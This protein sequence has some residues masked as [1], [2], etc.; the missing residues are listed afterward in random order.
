MDRSLSSGSVAAWYCDFVQYVVVLGVRPA[1]P[2]HRQHRM[3]ECNRGRCHTSVVSTR[4][5]C[6]ESPELLVACLCAAWCRTCDDYRT[7]FDRLRNE[8]A[9]GYRFLWVDIEDDEA[10][11]GD[12]DIDDFPTLLIARGSVPA[13]FGPV[14]PQV[15]VS[16]QLLSRAGEDSLGGVEG[17]AVHALVARLV[18]SRPP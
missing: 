15:A 9:V 12:V 4:D 5:T 18:R 2:T 13:F 8:F 17:E 10:L 7:T 3:L 16:R 14:T 11:V 1:G 6:P